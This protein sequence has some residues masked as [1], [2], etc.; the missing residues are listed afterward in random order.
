M[1]KCACGVE[2]VA[3]EFSM[4]CP[5]AE[6]ELSRF[7]SQKMIELSHT[8]HGIPKSQGGSLPDQRSEE[9]KDV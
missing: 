8:H 6:E 9:T 1:S 4:L 3:G 7:Y 5:V 2:E